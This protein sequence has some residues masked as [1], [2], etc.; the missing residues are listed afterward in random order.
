MPFSKNVFTT[1]DIEALPEGVRA[2]I[3]DSGCREAAS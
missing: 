1:A 2:G 3:L